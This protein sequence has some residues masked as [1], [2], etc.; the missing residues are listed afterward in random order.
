MALWE[1]MESIVEKY[2]GLVEKRISN[3]ENLSGEDLQEIYQGIQSFWHIVSSLERICRMEDCYNE[4]QIF[5]DLKTVR[6]DEEILKKLSWGMQHETGSQDVEL[7]SMNGEKIVIHG[8]QEA[9]FFCKT[10]LEYFQ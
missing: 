7:F 4:L 10:L 8:K 1:K 6:N 9:E 3:T 5:R 2:A